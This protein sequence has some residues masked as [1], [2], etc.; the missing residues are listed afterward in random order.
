MKKAKFCYAVL[1]ASAVLT[2]GTV[3]SASAAQWQALGDEW[4][5]VQNDGEYFKDGWK[6]DGN[7]YYYLGSDGI[8]L[9]RTL[10]EDDDNYY[11]LGSSGAMATN[12]W[13]FIQNPEWQGDELVGEGSWYYFGS[14]GKAIKSDGSKAKVY[15]VGDKKYVCD[16]Y[17]RM[18]SG[19]V[20]ESGEYV[21]SEEDWANGLYYADGEGDGSVVTNAWVYTT[22][23]DDTNEDETE[24]TYHFYFGSNG[25]KTVSTK[26]SIGGKEYF[27]DERGVAQYGWHKG[28]DDEWDWSYYGD[29]EEPHLRTGWF[30]A[31][32][33]SEMN[34]TAHDDGSV[35]WYYATSAGKTAAAEF[36]TIDGKTYAFNDKGELVTGLRKIEVDPDDKKKIK[37]IDS[38]N[39][40]SDIENVEKNIYVCYFGSDGAVKTG[41]QTLSIDGSS[42]TFDFKSSGSPKGAG[43]NGPNDNYIYVNGRRLAA[44]DGSKYGII[45]YEGKRYLVNESGAIQKNK[46]NVKDADG[47]YYCTGKHG[48]VVHEH[49]EE[50]CTDKEHPEE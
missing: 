46:K 40:I 24:P 50:K 44:E 27:F 7:L 34:P 39:Y 3:F 15:E 16:Y 21:E 5:Y 11:Y 28:D 35:Y 38:V 13:K 19:W 20:T 10:I 2:L 49:L 47:Y 18:M 22:V 1:T 4:V 17:G 48:I 36:R 45:S 25:K 26:K 23:P 30:Q 14:N 43:T 6:Q 8:M 37:H 32:P 33:D 12:V 41:T 31:V 9:R 42:Y 29:S